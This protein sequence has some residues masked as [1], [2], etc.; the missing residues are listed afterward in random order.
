MKIDKISFTGSSAV[1]RRIQEAAAKSNLKR[2]TLELG[3]E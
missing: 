2:T 3:G 1:G